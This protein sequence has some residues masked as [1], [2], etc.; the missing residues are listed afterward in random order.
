M[1]NHIYRLIVTTDSCVVANGGVDGSALGVCAYGYAAREARALTIV[2]DI[3]RRGNLEGVVLCCCAR[4]SQCDVITHLPA[5]GV[6]IEGY[7]GIIT[8]DL[9]IGNDAHLYH[10]VGLNHLGIVDA[11]V[12]ATRGKE[13]CNSSENR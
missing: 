1:R 5:C 9:C 6:A 8:L 11:H 7:A 3:L 10:L 13:C 12:L 4:K 2:G